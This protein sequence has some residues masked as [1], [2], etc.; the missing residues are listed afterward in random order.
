MKLIDT[1]THLYLKD[2]DEDIDAV[3]ARGLAEGIERFYL[4]AI[5]SSETQRVFLLQEKYPEQCFAMVGLHPCSVKADYAKE[6]SLV[7]DSLKST[8]YAGIGETGLDFY[9]DRTFEKEQYLA[10]EKQ[11]EWAIEFSSPIILHT[12]NATQ[13]TIDVVR[14]FASKGVKGI[15]HCFGGTLSEAQQ[16]IDMGFYLGI[17]GVVTYKNSGLDKVL[18]DVDLAHLVLETD[19]PYLTPV[20]FRGKRNESS[21]LKYVAAKIADIKGISVEEVG[22]I[23]SRNADKVFA[24]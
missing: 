22:E 1:H 6:L 11:L 20:P 4:P 9:W 7:Y 16:I 21:Y 13:E 23:T 12:R 3:I 24:N 5:D 17:G 15:F 10:L 2:F 18:A 8:R 14:H 19:S